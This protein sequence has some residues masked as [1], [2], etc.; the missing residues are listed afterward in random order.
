MN[1]AREDGNFLAADGSSVSGNQDLVQ[2]LFNQCIELA[3]FFASHDVKVNPALQDT[4]DALAEVKGQLDKQ[5]LTQDWSLRETDLFDH[6]K[7]L[8]SIDRKRA[9]G[10]FV[11]TDGN[12]PEEGQKVLLY[13]LRKS[14]AMVYHLLSQSKP[15]SEALQP[16]HNQL[17]T[18]KKCLLEVQ[19]SGGLSSPRDLFP[20]SMKLASIDNMRVCDCS[21]SITK[22]VSVFL[23]FV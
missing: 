20:F 5:V 9:N 18:L 12:S 6:M 17:H 13:L 21:Y 23:F 14:Y 19:K 2:D 15:V 3:Q 22:R 16:M 1:A 7:V 8:R 4:Y 10:K 11:G